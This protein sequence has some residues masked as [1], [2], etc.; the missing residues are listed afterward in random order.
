[1]HTMAALAIH[2]IK[3]SLRKNV[4]VLVLVFLIFAVLASSVL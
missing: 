4:L 1:M 3:D 2:T